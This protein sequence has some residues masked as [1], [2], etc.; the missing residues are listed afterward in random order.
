VGKNVTISKLPDAE[1]ANVQK[2]LAP[3]VDKAT[4]KLESEG[5]PGK[6]FLDAYQR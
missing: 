4:A 2:A 5:K 6:K 1:F 3:I